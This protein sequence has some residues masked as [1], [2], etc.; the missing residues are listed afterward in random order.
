MTPVPAEHAS[1]DG[2]EGEPAEDSARPDGPVENILD[3]LRDQKPQRQVLQN[4]PSDP[5]AS[6]KQDRQMVPWA[7]IPDGSPI[8]RR[9]GRIISQGDWWTFVFESD[10]A[11]RPQPPMK[12]LPNLNVE[13]MV[14]AAEEEGQTGLV[15]LVSGEVTV[16][17]GENY[18]LPRAALRRVDAGNLRQ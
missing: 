6:G 4:S 8:S 13:N 17:L 12:L 3:K 1:G 9:P 18:L 14:R 2:A 7:Q 15:F 10:D 16:F 5:M 11:D